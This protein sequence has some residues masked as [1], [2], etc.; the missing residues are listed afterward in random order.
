MSTKESNKNNQHKKGSIEAFRSNWIQRQESKRYHFKRGAPENQIQ[1]AFQNHWRVFR[2]ILGDIRTGRVLEVGSGRGS[3]AAFFSDAGFEVHLLDTSQQV[4]GIARDNFDLDGLLGQYTCGN[5]LSIPYPTGKFDIVM[6]IGLLE[7]FR[8]IEPILAEQLRVLRPGGFFLGYV[9]PEN[10]ISVQLLATPINAFLRLEHSVCQGFATRDI[11]ME[12]PPKE[13]LYRN[14]FPAEKYL[15]VLQTMRVQ[16]SGSFGM[17]PVPLISHSPRFPFS[18]MS[19]GRERVLVKLWQFLLKPCSGQ[20][21][22]PWSCHERWGL[23]FLVW[24]KR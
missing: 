11:K 5:A 7:H 3:M 10:F 20:I 4:L 24:A 1:F 18:L 22:D 13:D 19:S 21:N 9:V 23:A 15:S 14:N 8:E 2:Q 16:T 17:F 6:S 12:H